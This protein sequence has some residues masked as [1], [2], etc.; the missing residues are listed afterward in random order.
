MTASDQMWEMTHDML[1]SMTYDGAIL[2]F[3]NRINIIFIAI[4][5]ENI[6]ELSSMLWIAII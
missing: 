6:H 5:I 3:L 2:K 4:C 1:A